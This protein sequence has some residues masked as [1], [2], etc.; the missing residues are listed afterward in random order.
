MVAARRQICVTLARALCVWF[1]ATLFTGDADAQRRR[2]SSYETESISVALARIGG[3]EVDPSP[4]GKLI[5]RVHVVSLE[6]LEPRDPAPAFLNWF[7][8][9]SR[10][11]VIRQEVLLKEGQVF[12]P[13]LQAESERN[14]R[15]LPQLSVVLLVALRGSTPDRVRLLVITKD[16]WSL[17]MSWQPTIENGR[18]TFFSLAP[19]ETNLF[20]THQIVAG[21]M[22]F[23]PNTYALGGRYA[24][25]RI[26]GSRINASI[27][28][29]AILNCHTNKLDGATGSLL[30]GQPLY[31]SMAKWSWQVFAQWTS[32]LTHN[33]AGVDSAGQRR[34]I[35]TDG[36]TRRDD[37]I[38]VDVATIEDGDGEVV[39]DE[40]GNATLIAEFVEF[41]NKSRSEILRGQMVLTRSFFRRNKLNI[42]T[43]F[44]VDQRRTS[45]EDSI[46]ETRHFL[47]GGRVSPDDG[48]V[49][50]PAEQDIQPSVDSY[51][52]ARQEARFLG[53]GQRW[54]NPY[55]QL[56]AFANDAWRFLINY[57]S[58]G[59]QEDIRLGHD[60]YLR[61]YPVFAPLSSDDFLGVFASAAYTWPVGNGFLRAMSTAHLRV[62]REQERLSPNERRDM[63]A[64]AD[65]NNR[66]HFASPSLGIGR[67]VVD[68][69]AR[70]RPLRSSFPLLGLGGGSGGRLRGYPQNRFIGATRVTSTVEFRTI[71][72]NLFSVN[73]GAALFYDAGGVYNRIATGEGADRRERLQFDGGHNA[74]IGLRVLAPQLDRD[75]FRI[76]VAFALDSEG[77]G[78]FE[79]V[80][81]FEQAFFAPWPGP[82]VPLPQ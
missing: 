53:F 16:V 55:I 71:P 67:I 72:L 81:V 20:G 8:V 26:G 24:Y 51:L 68:G 5:E 37:P 60:L 7:H 4:N 11:Y 9:T 28:A 70:H 69:A 74:G 13:L 48:F 1:V 65:Y 59:L 22:V 43:G 29:S 10:E 80:A 76:D 14:L 54:V 18:L 52:R 3:G 32:L 79:S 40:D 82:P 23:T 25:P 34:P 49:R 42:S 30:Y 66:I 61:L 39:L 21:S 78:G 50:A 44:E 56:H 41:P 46:E 12:D 57:N 38:A 17:R 35:C 47:I 15:L 77:L 2:L 6:V 64:D 63:F 58:L 45:R 36:R 27:S 75:V 62:G 33:G 19:S 31:S 73:L